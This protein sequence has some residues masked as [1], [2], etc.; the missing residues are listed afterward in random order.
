MQRALLLL[1]VVAF[2][3]RAAAAQGDPVGPEFRV[4][5]Y[6]TGYQSSS[7]RGLGLLR[8]L[9]RRLGE[10]RA[11]TAR[12]YG[13]FGQRY[14]ST[15]APLG[16]E[17]RVNT[18]TTSHQR[19]PSVASDASGNFV[20]VWQSDA[21]TARATASSAS[22]TPAPARPSAPS[23]AST[24][25]RRIIQG[26]SGRGRGLLRQL[27]RRLAELQ[28][29][30]LGAAAS[31]ASATPA[32]ARPSAPSSASTRTRRTASAFRPW[33]R[34]PP[35][36]SSSSG[37]ATRRTARTAASSA[38]ATPAPARPSAPSSASTR[39]RR[40]ARAIAGRG[41]GRLRQLRRRLERATSR[42]ARTTASSASA[43]PAPARRSAPSSA[44]TP[45]RRHASTFRPSPRTPPATSSSSGRA[46]TRTARLR[47]LRP[48]LRQHRRAPRSRVPRQHVHDELPGRPSVASD[49]SGNFVV[50]WEST[51]TA[52]ATASSASAT[53]DRPGRA[54]ALP[55]GIAPPQ[56][57]PGKKQRRRRVPPA[58]E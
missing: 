54:D 25:T 5:T 12:A 35:A 43:T 57:Q 29:G 55:G 7:G 48:A 6:T 9:R 24:P 31:S 52:R 20:V 17:F 33:P 2:I 1:V 38:S 58:G 36:T 49:S 4:N 26:C 27:R 46:T 39:T 28:P 11:R 21:R 51:R 8:Q 18:Y 44:S 47:R 3:P 14:A 13:V 42:T 32:P 19:H 50:V 41:L 23:S 56:S 30:R 22:A 45:T 37:R 15:G 53:A 10:R 40:V 34:T 16:P